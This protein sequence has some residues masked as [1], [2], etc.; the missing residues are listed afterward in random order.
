MEWQAR[1]QTFGEGM[2][3]WRWRM[4][5]KFFL[6][7]WFVIWNLMVLC[8][9]DFSACE[10]QNELAIAGF[11]TVLCVSLDVAN[12]QVRC[13][14]V[15]I[16][17]E[18][19]IC[20]GSAMCAGRPCFTHP[21]IPM[22]LPP[23]SIAHYTRVPKPMQHSI[24][25]L[26]DF[27]CSW[28]L[29]YQ[30]TNHFRFCGQN[31]GQFFHWDKPGQKKWFEPIIAGGSRTLKILEEVQPLYAYLIETHRISTVAKFLLVDSVFWS[32]WFCPHSIFQHFFQ[33]AIE[34]T[35]SFWISIECVWFPHRLYSLDSISK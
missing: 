33:M 9:S 2:G 7:G 5:S 23:S 11:G 16:T 17:M 1:G 25:Y 15:N 10:I 3:G 14:V 31:C 19:M 34:F 27:K 26:S 13:G 6:G 24:E 18:T 35:F 30:T 8:I 21:K 32:V 28:R 29:H 22:F 20:G 12:V 4:C